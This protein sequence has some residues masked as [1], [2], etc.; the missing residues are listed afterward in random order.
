MITH[1]PHEVIE[2]YILNSHNF[3]FTIK[4]FTILPFPHERIK[5]EEEGKLKN[6]NNKQGF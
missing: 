6:F 4:F 5:E 3:L 2:K 1:H